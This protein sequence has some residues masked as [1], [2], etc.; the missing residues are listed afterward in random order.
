MVHDA[1]FGLTMS[2]VDALR[3]DPSPDAAALAEL[4]AADEDAPSIGDHAPG[5]RWRATFD[6]LARSVAAS[7]PFLASFAGLGVG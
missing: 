4:L 5:P 7:P 2:L 3:A 6:T 1:R